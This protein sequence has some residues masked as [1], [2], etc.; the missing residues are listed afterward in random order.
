MGRGQTILIVEDDPGVRMVSVDC[1]TD[2]GYRVL[3]AGDAATALR[4]LDQHP[5]VSLL[6]T[7]VVLPQGL[8]GRQLADEARRRRPGLPVL[9][10]TGYTQNAIVHNGMLDPGVDM[11]GKPFTLAEVARK[12]AQVTARSRPGGTG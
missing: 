5:E 8:N 11:I 10:T 12:L 7:D 4:L 9:F 1:L 3:D 2:L 6:F